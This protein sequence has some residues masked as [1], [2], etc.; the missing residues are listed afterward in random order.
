MIVTNN[1]VLSC[2]LALTI[3]AGCTPPGG[4]FNVRNLSTLHVQSRFEKDHEPLIVS[5]EELDASVEKLSNMLTELGYEGGTIHKSYGLKP[6]TGH[7]RSMTFRNPENDWIRCHISINKLAVNIEFQ[8]IEKSPGSDDY[9]VD[10]NDILSIETRV[11]TI[12]DFLAA[13]F[14][15]GTVSI[16]TFNEELVPNEISP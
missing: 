10:E 11:S 15:N 5:R 9:Y 14:P 3:F 2:L 12:E 8:A 7:S 4:A 1:Q 16:V 13:E 6:F